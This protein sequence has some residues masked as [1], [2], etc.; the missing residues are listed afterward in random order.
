M[1]V[2]LIFTKMQIHS[3]LL[4]VKI[5]L[6]PLIIIQL[7]PST[8]VFSVDLHMEDIKNIKFFVLSL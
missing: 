7:T 8:E 6:T 1:L 3:F 4:Y 2:Q 5:N